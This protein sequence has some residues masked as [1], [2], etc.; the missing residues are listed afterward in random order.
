[1]KTNDFYIHVQVTMNLKSYNCLIKSIVGN[2]HKINSI[3][4]LL[5]FS[6]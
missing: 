6:K 5:V 1:M 2:D 4:F 3:Q